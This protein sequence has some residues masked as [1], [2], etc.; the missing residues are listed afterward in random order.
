MNVDCITWMQVSQ[1]KTLCM[2]MEDKV[3]RCYTA[4]RPLL[5]AHLRQRQ[6]LVAVLVQH[7]KRLGCLVR[8]Q[9]R[10]QVLPLYV[11]PAPR[12]PLSAGQAGT[13]E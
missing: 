10:L 4:M 12:G 3:T 6:A 9:E 11:V 1:Q 7:G 5:A 8:R 13:I 2:S